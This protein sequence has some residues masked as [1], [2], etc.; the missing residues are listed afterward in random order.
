MKDKWIHDLHDRMDDFEMDAPDGLWE[1]LQHV[2]VAS[3]SVKPRPR[4]I[5]RRRIYGIAASV[6]VILSLS[7]YFYLSHKPVP[8]DTV[9]YISEK[10][11]IK[12]DKKTDIKADI[13]KPIDESYLSDNLPAT[14]PSANIVRKNIASVS[15]AP[16]VVPAT[17]TESSDVSTTD[18]TVQEV[19]VVPPHEL[20]DTIQ[21]QEATPG[22]P[23]SRDKNK[24]ATPV[25]IASVKPK[26]H[27]LSV[28]AYTTGG[29][30]S[31][32]TH[33]ST[34][35]V[36]IS[37]VGPADTE[38]NDSPKLGILLYNQGKEI[39]T[40]IHHRQPIR[41][42]LSLGYRLNRR[43]SLATG[44]TYT[45]LTS[46]IRDGSESHYFTG[47]Q[48]LHYIGL[49]LSVRYDIFQWKR[50]NLYASAG[51]LVEKNIS[52]KA[53]RNYILDNR[54]ERHDTEKIKD[55]PLQWSFNLSSG[56]E[57]NLTQQLG[58]FAEPGVS[59][60]IDNKSPVRNIYKERP[61]NFNLNLGIRFMIDN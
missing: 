31:N 13:I 11:D 8:A 44:L 43:L 19:A 30:N 48:V 12:T 54:T 6:M 33:T 56:I 37:S 55:R 39:R 38:W 60:Y 57:F 34:G 9:D 58:L 25:Y 40:D 24:T 29:L 15:H 52:G 26:T 16:K 50:L 28:G 53:V 51:I 36:S 17:D 2:P 41:A 35:D 42:G 18:E 47:E 10:T 3:G 61:V 4:L 46:D 27:R 32:I 20:I 21:P 7:L 14:V 45:N 1:S 5:T 23:R 22:I 49:P 59:C